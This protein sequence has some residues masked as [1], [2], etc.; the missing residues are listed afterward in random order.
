MQYYDD[1]NDEY[2]FIDLN[3]FEQSLNQKKS[4]LDGVFY[5]LYNSKTLEKTEERDSTI[6]KGRSVMLYNALDNFDGY[7]IGTDKPSKIDSIE[8]IFTVSEEA[9]NEKA[10]LVEANGL[11]RLI[12]EVGNT[13]TNVTVDTL[14]DDDAKRE[15][16]LNIVKFTYDRNDGEYGN[17]FSH[18]VEVK[19][20]RSYFTS[21]IAAG[22]FDDVLNTEYTTIASTFTAGRIAEF[23]DYEKF[24]FAYNG[25]DGK[26]TTAFENETEEEYEANKQ[27]AKTALA[28]TLRTEQ[29]T[30]KFRDAI[31]GVNH[32][33]N[34]GTAQERDSTKGEHYALMDS[35]MLTKFINETKFMENLLENFDLNEKYGESYG[36]AQARWNAL[37]DDVYNVGPE[38]P[39]PIKFF[40]EEV[41]HILTVITNVIQLEIPTSS[42]SSS[43]PAPLKA[44]FAEEEN[45][46]NT[47]EEDEPFEY[48]D[49]PSFLDAAVNLFDGWI[50]KN[51][52]L[53]SALDLDSRIA[54]YLGKALVIVNKAIILNQKESNFNSF[55]IVLW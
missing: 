46:E 10:Y 49:Y 37:I 12:D 9:N 5:F 48:K 28:A 11:T 29:T 36:E 1:V 27:A 3:D 17:G 25:V 16:I 7:L 39:L 44:R 53:G 4:F 32:M 33:N 18:D 23:T 55:F 38:D 51:D 21:E 34:D 15:N 26:A 45:T 14:R 41:N 24:Y 13:I 30:S 50:N 54:P 40:K 35:K 8:K 20:A 2:K 6:V 22:I 52:L 19:T 47:D 42:S 31:C 43:T